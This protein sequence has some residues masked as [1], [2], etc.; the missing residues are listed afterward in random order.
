[1]TFCG[2]KFQLRWHTQALRH[3]DIKFCRSRRA[4]P[5]KSPRTRSERLHGTRFDK[6]T[7]S[8]RTASMH[9]GYKVSKSR[10]TAPTVACQMWHA[11]NDMSHY[12]T[13]CCVAFIRYVTRPCCLDSAFSAHHVLLVTFRVRLQASWSLGARLSAPPS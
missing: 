10:I 8:Q 4:H 7:P 9:G 13:S 12:L 3:V 11:V 1:M 5:Q 2:N 6:P